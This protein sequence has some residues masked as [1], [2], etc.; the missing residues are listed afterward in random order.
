MTTLLFLLS[1]LSPPALA[2]SGLESAGNELEK[3]ALA[4]GATLEKLLKSGCLPS[5]KVAETLERSRA[6]EAEVS[7]F[8]K[9]RMT[10]L[11]ANVA[12]PM[13]LSAEGG[14]ICDGS[15]R[16]LVDEL[17]LRQAWVMK[18]RAELMRAGQRQLGA[19]GSLLSLQGYEVRSA[20]CAKAAFRG[21]KASVHGATRALAALD[22]IDITLGDHETAL[23]AAVQES[24]KRLAAC[25]PRPGE[26]EAPAVASGKGQ[27]SA[28]PSPPPSRKPASAGGSDIT[29]VK[30]D[31]AKRQR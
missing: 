19:L 11:L 23:K 21:L 4:S 5:K 13:Q 24:S 18:E 29:G 27:G 16:A 12:K 25:G 9:G 2:T 8:V 6:W 26:A 3:S 20:A 14:G 31:R 22:D 10:G 15:F 1:L 7:R 17:G 28:A 30:E